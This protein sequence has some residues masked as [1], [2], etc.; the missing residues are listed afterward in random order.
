MKAIKTPFAFYKKHDQYA[1]GNANGESHNV[2]NGISLMFQQVT[3]GYL[4]NV[5]DHTDGYYKVTAD[6]PATNAKPF[7]QKV[8]SQ[9]FHGTLSPAV[10]RL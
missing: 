2:N 4:E 5:I 8:E 3:D 10:V 9:I 1:T 7:L 6:G